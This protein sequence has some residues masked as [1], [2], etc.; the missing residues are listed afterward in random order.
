MSMSADRQHNFLEQRKKLLILFMDADSTSLYVN[1]EILSCLVNIYCSRNCPDYINLQRSNF[2]LVNEEVGEISF[3]ILARDEYKK[4]SKFKL[5][6]AN[7]SYKLIPLMRRLSKFYRRRAKI[8]SE[9][10]RYK[11]PDPSSP[12]IAR[13]V[14]VFESIMNELECGE[15][16][17]MSPVISKYAYQMSKV[18][19]R[20]VT[21][22]P[23]PFPKSN[24]SSLLDVRLP[25]FIDG[26]NDKIRESSNALKTFLNDIGYTY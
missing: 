9:K 6:R 24:P 1:G 2:M 22:L 11:N 25:K 3:S 20:N 17:N 14:D 10:L 21:D 18:G 8:T 5:D 26:L 23:K 15:W 4:G 13:C 19:L 12:Q 7:R 16:K